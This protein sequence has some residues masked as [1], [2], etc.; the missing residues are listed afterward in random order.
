MTPEDLKELRVTSRRSPNETGPPIKVYWRKDVE[1]YSMEKWGSP[2]GLRREKERRSV[3]AREESEKM[4][5]PSI[6]SIVNKLIRL[7]KRRERAEA[8]E[9]EL[10]QGVGRGPRH[11]VQVR[12]RYTLLAF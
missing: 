12:V 9:R 11:G 4:N 6:N 7:Q 5:G 10:E 3:V 8:L 2:E 1:K